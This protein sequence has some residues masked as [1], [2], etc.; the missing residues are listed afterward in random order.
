MRE[1]LTSDL[2]YISGGA[3]YVDGVSYDYMFDTIDSV[4]GDAEMVRLM[5]L[6]AVGFIGAA[7]GLPIN[8]TIIAALSI[9]QF[10]YDYELKNS[11][12]W[13]WSWT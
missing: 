1:L 6:G 10:A 9:S 11:E 12:L 13:P 7:T 3:Y 4:L 8:Y 2:K 5:S